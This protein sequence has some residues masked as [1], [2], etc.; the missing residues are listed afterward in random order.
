MVRENGLVVKK[1]EEAQATEN[2]K[3]EKQVN[4]HLRA[5]G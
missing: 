2:V 3:G 1:G 4:T 5:M